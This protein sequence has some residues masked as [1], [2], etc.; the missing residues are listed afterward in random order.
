MF[1]KNSEGINLKLSMKCMFFMQDL[2]VKLE[3]CKLIIS[4]AKKQQEAEANK[5]ASILLEQLDDEKKK[6]ECKKEQAQKKRGKK[7]HKKKKKPSSGGKP[8]SDDGHPDDD[9]DDFEREDEEF[10]NGGFPFVNSDQRTPMLISGNYHESL[11]V[12]L[13]SLDM[14]S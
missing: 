7:K 2:L 13:F 8:S 11:F 4:N 14:S 6:E 10:E 5:N 9:R 1:V 12:L 3:E